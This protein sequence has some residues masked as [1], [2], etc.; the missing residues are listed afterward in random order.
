L[1]IGLISAADIGGRIPRHLGKERESA[2]IAAL[3]AAY[4]RE[5][6]APLSGC[7]P[8]G[9]AQEAIA[10][11]PQWSFVTKISALK[12]RP[13][14]IVTSN[15]PYFRG[16]EGFASALRRAGNN[17]VSTLHLPTDH[18]YSDQRGP[19]SSSVLRWLATFSSPTQ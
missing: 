10:N 9:L 13:I 15:D 7:T 14:L 17:R 16:D 3:S 4:E 11:A 2:T 8:E 1:G 19:L 6:M 12:S 5:G 18:A